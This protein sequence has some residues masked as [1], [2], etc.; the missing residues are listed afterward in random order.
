[1]AQI[2]RLK[3]LRA[4]RNEEECQAALEALSKA[5]ETGKGNLLALAIEAAKKR[6]SLGEISYAC[7]KHVGRYKAVIITFSGVYYQK[8]KTTD[9]QRSSGT[10]S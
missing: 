2:E 9:L 10:G 6:A 3:K 1:L 4:E 5:V 7:E 8:A